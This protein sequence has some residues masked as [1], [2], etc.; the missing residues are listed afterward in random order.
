M[1]LLSLL[2]GL[3]LLLGAR[4]HPATDLA[5]VADRLGGREVFDAITSLRL[6]SDVEAQGPAGIVSVRS[7]ASVRLPDAVRLGQQLPSGPVVTIWTDDAARTRSGNVTRDLRPEAARQLR[8]QLYLVLPV[9]LAQRNALSLDGLAW[10]G[11]DTILSLR[12]PDLAAPIRLVV[13]PDGLPASVST[14]LAGSEVRVAFDQY[15]RRGGLLLPSRT[16]QT[17]DGDTTGTT[18]LV[19]VEIDPTL[20]DRLFALD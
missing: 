13:G 11:D 4:A 5:A 20:P 8:G 14:T 18:R 9:L 19:S 17:V 3:L 10:D 2:G 1:R 7:T 12:A 15:G 16:V 6:V